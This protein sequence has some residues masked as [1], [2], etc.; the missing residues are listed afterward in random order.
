MPLVASAVLMGVG[1]LTKAGI[2]YFGMK[3]A[4]KERKAFE[5]SHQLEYSKPEELMSRAQGMVEYGFTPQEQAAFQQQMARN[6]AAQLRATQGAAPNLSQQVMA[7]V[8]YGNVQNII[9]FAE[10]NARLQRQR[11]DELY[12]R[13]E[14]ADVRNVQANLG[15]LQQ[16]G[17]AESQY[18]T[19]LYQAA[20]DLGPQAAFLAMQA[21][22]GTGAETNKQMT[23]RM[24]DEYEITRGQNVISDMNNYNYPDL[25]QYNSD[26]Y[27]R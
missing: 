18:R 14:R 24:K 2:G 9:K 21:G 6:E 5:R 3:K 11:Y 23:A 19:M 15:T 13:L 1:A 16:Y 8:N 10:A 4:R 25:G 20:S 22:G 12:G 26:T 17:Q 7:G 27:I